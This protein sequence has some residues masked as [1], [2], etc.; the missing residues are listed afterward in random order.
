MGDKEYI[1]KAN[2]WI[3]SF[4]GTRW[5]V[6]FKFSEEELIQIGKNIGNNKE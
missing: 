6:H 4:K 1:Q 2:E 3:E 5:E